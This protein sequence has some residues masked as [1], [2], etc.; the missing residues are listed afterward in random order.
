M[1]QHADPAP[2]ESPV[3]PGAI[4]LSIPVVLVDDHLI[5]RGGVRSLLDD[6]EFDIVGEAGTQAEALEVVRAVQPRIVLLDIRLGPSDG[7]QV[8][9]L[10]KAEH[11]HLCV[12][13][14]T[15]YDNPTF[16]ARAVASG[17]AG[18][19]L[20]DVGRDEL[21]KAL[22]AVERGELLLTRQDL[23]RSLRNLGS[24]AGAAHD[25]IE[26]LTHNAVPWGAPYRFPPAR[27]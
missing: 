2:S 27:Q 24:Q 15:S 11:P 8:L 1:S 16:M 17:A 10:L 21:L 3:A 19:L 14:L 9:H 18:Y 20:K 7:L 5:W 13:M 23:A 26:P 12:L 6:S 22:R 25:L 4:P